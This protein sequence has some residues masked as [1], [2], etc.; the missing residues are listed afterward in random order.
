[1]ISV[2]IHGRH[3][4]ELATRTCPSW[5]EAARFIYGNVTVSGER[6]HYAVAL[7]WQDG[8]IV[9]APVLYI[10]PSGRYRRTPTPFSAAT[11]LSLADLVALAGKGEL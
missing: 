9:G 8:S 5:P 2:T 10:T 7:D 11:A 3:G 1:M 4:I 6:V